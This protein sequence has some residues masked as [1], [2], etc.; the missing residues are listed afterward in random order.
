MDTVRKRHVIQVGETKC[1]DY[2]Q[3]KGSMHFEVDE[4]AVDGLKASTLSNCGLL[5]ASLQTQSEHSKQD[6]KTL[7]DVQMVVQVSK[8]KSDDSLHRRI[9]SPLE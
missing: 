6:T 1:C 2:D 8:H 7:V 3:G 9:F 4:I 5:V